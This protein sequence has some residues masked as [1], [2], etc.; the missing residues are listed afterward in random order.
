METYVVSRETGEKKLGKRKLFNIVA[1]ND[2][3]VNNNC[4]QFL[5]TA[6][7][8]FLEQKRR[9]RERKKKRKSGKNRLLVK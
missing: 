5:A 7:L 6:L 8:R 1:R 2:L 9:K 3:S 4:N